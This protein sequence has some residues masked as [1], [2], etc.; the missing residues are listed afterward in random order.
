MYYKIKG[1]N[2]IIVLILLIYFTAIMYIYL[3]N[4]YKLYVKSKSKVSQK[5][6]KSKSKVSQNI[7]L[8]FVIC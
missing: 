3:F 6:H 1:Q 7:I 2:V 8:M 4:K 5:G